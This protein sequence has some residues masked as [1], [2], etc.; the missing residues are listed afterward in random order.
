MTLAVVASLGACA[1]LA[2]L[3]LYLRLGVL[4]AGQAAGSFRRK[5][6]GSTLWYLL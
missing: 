5:A 4:N 1:E 6:T 3:C 2:R